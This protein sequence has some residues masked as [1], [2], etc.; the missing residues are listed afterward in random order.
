MAHSLIFG[1]GLEWTVPHEFPDC[2]VCQAVMKPSSVHAGSS[3]FLA[4]VVSLSLMYYG[5]T[6]RKLFTLIPTPGFAHSYGYSTM[7]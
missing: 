4:E 6:S 5:L 1:Y 2:I 7:N 3:H